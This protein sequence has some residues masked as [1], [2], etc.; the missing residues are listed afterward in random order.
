M[1]LTPELIEQVQALTSAV[2]EQMAAFALLIVALMVVMSYFALRFVTRLT[3]IFERNANEDDKRVDTFSALFQR[4]A[5]L[6]QHQI[7]INAQLSADTT[8]RNQVQLQQ[9]DTLNKMLAEL[10]A[11]RSDVRAWPEVAAVEIRKLQEQVND[12]QKTIDLLVVTADNQHI[13][14]QKIQIAL[15]DL[16]AGVETLMTQ[17]A[18]LTAAADSESAAATILPEPA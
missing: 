14:V 15:V 7:E 10:K 18:P 13:E 1:T 6:S 9:A 8:A 12:L 11:L 4:Q 17:I 2:N 16:R 5:D 3:A